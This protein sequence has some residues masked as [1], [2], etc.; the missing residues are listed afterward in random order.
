LWVDE[1]GHSSKL[2]ETVMNILTNTSS[3]RPRLGARKKILIIRTIVIVAIFNYFGT[4][5]QI[6]SSRRTASV[7]SDDGRPI[8]HTFYQKVPCGEDDLLVAW[9][10]A[11]TTA[12]FDARVLKLEDAKRHPYFEQMEKVIEPMFGQ[13]YNAMCFYRWLAMAASGGG[14]MCDYDTF[15]TNFPMDEGT[16]LPYGGQF[17]SFEVHV[18]SLISGTAEEWTR[19]TKL[20]IEAIPR[21]EEDL[22]SDMHAF[23]IL[24][25]EKTHNVHFQPARLNVRQG[26]PYLKA[27]SPD[28]PREVDCEAMAGGRAV[29]FAHQ[30]TSE[31]FE[32]E[33]FPLHKVSERDALHQRGEAAR[34]FMADWRDQCGGSNIK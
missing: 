14:W 13:G 25:N 32:K 23:E 7:V 19:V 30:Y 28:S 6:Q 22:K 17:T 24:R 9:K 12:G 26:F 31:S 1:K 2:N 18:P 10:E 20:L 21:V 11:W 8:M 29:H 16:N 27:L 4:T 34:V 3:L 15:P 33:M 5:F